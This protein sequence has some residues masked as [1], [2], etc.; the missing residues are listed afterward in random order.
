MKGAQTDKTGAV[1]HLRGIARLLLVCGPEAFQEQPLLSAFEG[2]RAIQVRWDLRSTLIAAKLTMQII[3]GLFGRQRLFL[4]SEQW[5]TV[6]WLQHPTLKTP[7]SELL[8]I[9]VVVPGILQDY[10]SLDSSDVTS[11]T[12][13]QEL[14]A[15]VGAQLILLYQWRWQWQIRCAHEVGADTSFPQ[16]YPAATAPTFR[17]R[18]RRFVVASELMLYNAAL[19]WLMALMFKINP[20]GGSHAIQACATTAMP[21]PDIVASTSFYPLWLP[22]GTA[23]LREPALETCRIFE[24]VARHHDS[25]REPTYLYLF[26]IGMAM[27]A[28]QDD[29]EAM[30]WIKALL[31]A[32]PATAS[33]AL[34]AN[35]AG[36]GFYLSR[37]A[38]AEPGIVQVQGDLF[39]APDI[40]LFGAMR[41]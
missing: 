6:P 14:Q 25:S 15:R 22:G 23:S 20:N 7:Q 10:E 26:P 3:A 18:F 13:L 1:F 33:Y 41:I 21:P 9:L 37:E 5:R 39:T 24:W 40:E 35:Q 8:D 27:T 17:L 29:P 28:L 38:F 11:Q 19:M 34:G 16:S 31:N 12:Q 30:T 2:A 4:E 32:S 36:F